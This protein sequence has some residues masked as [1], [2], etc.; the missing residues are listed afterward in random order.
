MKNFLER[1]FELSSNGTSI[2]KE[3]IAGIITFLTMSY[4]LVVNPNVLADAGMDRHALFTTT[5]LA[6]IAATLLMG[7]YAKLPIA[8]APG[9]GLNSFFAY[10]VVLTMGYTWQFALTA[11]FIEGIIFLLL[12][13]FNVRELIVRSIPKVLKEAIPA[14]IGLFITLIGLKSAGVVVA[15]PNTLVRLGDFSQHSVWITMTGLIVTGILLIRNVNGAILFG[16]LSATIFGLILGDITLPSRI[17]DLPPSIEP[18]FGEAIKPMFTAEGWNKI[19]SL[20]MLVVVFTFLFVNL[21]DTVGTLI[22]VISKTNLADK[23]GNFPQMK[24][25]LFTDAMGTTIGSMLGTSPVTSYVES[26]SGVASGGRTGLTAVSVA[27]M[28]ALALFLGPIFLMIPAAATAPALI[29]VGLFMISSVVN[30]K[31]DDLS[32]ALPAFLT[33]VFMPFT[34]SIAEG[35]VFGM[36][37]FT[38]LKLGTKQHKDITPTVYVLSILF[39]LK[40]VLD[41]VTAS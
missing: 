25:A 31:F 9:M 29:I 11:V 34:Y 24:K 28:F 23:D 22:G 14:G 40:I 6:T 2:K 16:I 21:F 26:A 36:L 39:L 13:F 41:V 7:F 5:A 10:S 19:F 18:I 32:E 17:V 33:I 35:I 4:I 30:I 27:I 38:I 8:Q 3:F 12:T 20:D 37:S 1:Y 15:D